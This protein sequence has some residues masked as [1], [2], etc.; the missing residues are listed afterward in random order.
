[1]IGLATLVRAA[2]RPHT[3]DVA[4]V[5]IEPGN[6]GTTGSLADYRRRQSYT[7]VA[8]PEP[9]LRPFNGLLPVV[10]RLRDVDAAKIAAV[11]AHAPRPFGAPV[12]FTPPRTASLLTGGR[13]PK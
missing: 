11:E 3:H 10:W 6:F 1:M 8:P 4:H 2:W 7:I 9:R 12:Q 13:A 5:V